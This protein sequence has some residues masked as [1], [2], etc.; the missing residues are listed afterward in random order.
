MRQLFS[1]RFDAYSSTL[2]SIRYQITVAILECIPLAGA[3]DAQ[4]ALLVITRPHTSA[5]D[6]L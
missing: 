6:L 3:L 1:D 5:V 2:P 4:G